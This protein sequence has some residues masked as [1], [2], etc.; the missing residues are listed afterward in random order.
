LKAM[1]L[2]SRLEANKEIDTDNRRRRKQ[3]LAHLRDPSKPTPSPRASLI[4]ITSEEY[5]EIRTT[6]S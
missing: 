2:Q 4:T 1:D 3:E 5:E 6:P